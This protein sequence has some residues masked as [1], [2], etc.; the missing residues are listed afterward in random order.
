MKNCRKGTSRHW[1]QRNDHKKGTLK[2]AL[3]GK[4]GWGP[5]CCF[6]AKPG[7]VFLHVHRNILFPIDTLDLSDWFIQ[8]GIGSK[9]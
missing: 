2:E 8:I 7:N 4:P 6:R 1:R 5:L 9:K 3:T